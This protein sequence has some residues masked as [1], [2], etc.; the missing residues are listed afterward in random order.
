MDMYGGACACCGE[1]RFAFLTIDHI[2]GG[3]RKHREQFTSNDA[4]YRWLKQ[5]Q[6][7]GFRV[8]CY[9]CNCARGNFGK[10]P[11]EFAK[12]IADF[13]DATPAERMTL[14]VL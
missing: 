5:E 10:C 2:E 12:R 11:H 14:C 9:N 13:I 8:L 4:L 6:R 7:E 3:G 1:Y